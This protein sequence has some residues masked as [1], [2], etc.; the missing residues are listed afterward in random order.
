M[1]E[2]LLLGLLGANIGKSLAPAL[3]EDAAAAVGCGASEA[4][5]GEGAA[6]WAATIETR[7]IL[8][9]WIW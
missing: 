7:R 2:R 6:T 9:L 5:V 4:A 1:S 8:D 3:H